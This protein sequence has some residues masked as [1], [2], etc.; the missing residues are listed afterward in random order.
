M[1]TKKTLTIILSLH[2][3][4]AKTTPSLRSTAQPLPFPPTNMPSPSHHPSSTTQTLYTLPTTTASTTRTTTITQPSTST[5]TPVLRLR[6]TGPAPTPSRRIQWA[7][8]VIDNEGLGRKSSKGI[9]L[10][11]P[12]L[13]P[14]SKS[15]MRANAYSPSSLLYLPRPPRC[16]RIV[17]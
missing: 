12:F 15:R 9:A 17:L 5:S 4:S 10:H 11:I 1:Q 8:N 7:E 2:T 13:P 3:S 6:A 14:P 16:R